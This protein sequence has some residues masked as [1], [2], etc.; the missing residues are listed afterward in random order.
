MC[1]CV[2]GGRYRQAQ[3]VSVHYRIMYQAEKRMKEEPC[4]GYIQAIVTQ[5]PS[6]CCTVKGGVRSSLSDSVFS[7][8]LKVSGFFFLLICQWFQIRLLAKVAKPNSIR[9]TKIFYFKKRYQFSFLFRDILYPSCDPRGN[10]KS[11][12]SFLCVT[13]IINSPLPQVSTKLSHT[14]P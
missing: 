1:V 13:E 14:Q 5:A 8:S 2:A 10:E 9:S 11:S 4:L 6:S 3:G 12:P 7:E